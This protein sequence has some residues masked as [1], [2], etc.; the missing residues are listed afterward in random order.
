LQNSTVASTE[1]ITL[2]K[3]DF[4]ELSDAGFEDLSEKLIPVLTRV[5]SRVKV[6]GAPSQTFDLSEVTKA[7]DQRL[8][9]TQPEREK[10]QAFKTIEEF[11]PDWREIVGD[12]NAPVKSPWRAWVQTQPAAYQKQVLE[13]WNPL[14]VARSIDK[15]TDYNERLAAQPKAKTAV[16][17]RKERLSEAVTKKS[18]AAR[19]TVLSDDE[20]FDLGFKTGNT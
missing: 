9:E 13:T 8:T 17:T 11:Y 15:F 6:K 10:A 18:S 12:P 4:K 5:M 20:Q 19:E 2:S 1:P 7:V 3:A 16:D 14:V